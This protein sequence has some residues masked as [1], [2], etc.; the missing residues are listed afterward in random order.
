MLTIIWGTKYPYENEW[1][2][3][4]LTEIFNKLNIE[5][6]VINIA[7]ITHLVRNAVF[8]LNH[9]TNYPPYLQQ[10]ELNSVPFGVI[11]LSDE[12][13]NDNVVFYNYSMCKFIYRNYFH[14]K[15]VHNKVTFFPLG[16]KKEY[17]KDFKLPDLRLDMFRMGDHSNPLFQK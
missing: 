13:V 9:D 4:W 5:Y 8:V 11:H 15:Y 3:D 6:T 14:P 17:W 1:E 10:Y 7:D 12:W 2:R 16:Y